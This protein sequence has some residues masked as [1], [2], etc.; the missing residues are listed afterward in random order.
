[1]KRYIRIAIIVILA[2]AILAPVTANADGASGLLTIDNQNKYTGMNKTYAAGYVPTVSGGKVKVVLPLV[3]SA[4]IQGD[5]I[6]V[7]PGLGTPGSSP[8]VF[9]NYIE[10][11]KLIS[12]PVNGGPATVS[13]YLVNLTLPLASGRTRGSYPVTLTV[14]YK[15][16]SGADVQQSFT[17]FVTVSGKDPNAPPATEAPRHQPKVIVSKYSVDPN[18]VVAGQGFKLAFTLSNTST[19]YN[20]SNIKVT[21]KSSD[22]DLYPTDNTNTAYYKSLGKGQSI[23]IS[24]PMTAKVDAKTDPHSVNV[25]VEYEDDKAASFTASEDIPVTVTQ[26]LRLEPD[27]PNIP[28]SM[29]AGDTA[30]ITMQLINKGRSTV[31]NVM[32][33]LSAPGLLPE[34]SAFLGNMEPGTAKPAQITVFAGTRD[35]TSDSGSSGADVSASDMFGV[36][37]GTITITYE[38]EFG[39]QYSSKVNIKTKINA[40]VVPSAP[41]TKPEQ[42]KAGQWWVSAVIAAAL[43]LAV[44][45][46]L[47]L[48]RRN[49]MRK[50]QSRDVQ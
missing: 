47:A 40:P 43:I 12:H 33:V 15:D 7:T 29:V 6:T 44:I 38:D 2:L 16:G 23:D 28:D 24:I 34:A 13:A 3:P 25:T 9:G 50:V 37:S 18:P 19:S 46:L 8:F 21:V 26:P 4:A 22:G 5:K 11:V 39:K 41:E 35:M 10:T 48:S 17:L 14:D 30:P 42:P 27:A 45:F 36:T 31:Y 32:C 49:R 1:M 20:V